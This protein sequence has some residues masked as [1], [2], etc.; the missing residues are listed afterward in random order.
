MK[1][2]DFASLFLG[3]VQILIYRCGENVPPAGRFLKK[4]R[5]FLFVKLQFI[6][7]NEMFFGSLS[8]FGSGCGTIKKNR[9]EGKHYDVWQY[10]HQST[11]NRS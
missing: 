6:N 8:T 11:E 10:R 4:K 1:L 2:L 9:G 3:R 5:P 7:K